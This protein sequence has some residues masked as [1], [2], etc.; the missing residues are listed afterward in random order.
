M[1]SVS[2]GE[3]PSNLLNLKFSNCRRLFEQPMQWK[4]QSLTALTRLSIH[5]IHDMVDSF[6]EEGLLPATLRALDINGLI[7]L[8]SLNGKA[9][10]HVTSL[11]ILEI[12][13]CL[14]LQCVPEE[15]LPTPLFLLEIRGCPLLI[16]QCLKDTGEDWS[17]IDHIPI[18]ILS[19][20]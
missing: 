18:I 12:S 16:Q 4:L 15:G 13:Y 2:E 14:Q 10:Q 19:D 20:K 5:H 3:L 17:K 9:F 11:I 7:N 1:E 8:R 6:P